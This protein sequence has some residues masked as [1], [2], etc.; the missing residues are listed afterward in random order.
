M[1]AADAYSGMCG[2][3][4]EARWHPPASQGS[5]ESRSHRMGRSSVR[6]PCPLPCNG[7]AKRQLPVIRA[8][9]CF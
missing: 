9:I 8:G 6:L 7:I 5:W 2:L 1:P 3:P 4:Q